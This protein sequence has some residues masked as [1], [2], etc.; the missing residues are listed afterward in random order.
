MVELY[1][2]PISHLFSDVHP[3]LM[4][5]LFLQ[6]LLL[7]NFVKRPS[8]LLVVNRWVLLAIFV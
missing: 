4:L 3:F 5:T 2:S 8:K 1:G 6:V 7:Q